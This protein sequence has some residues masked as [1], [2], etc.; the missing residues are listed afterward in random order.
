MKKYFPA[1]LKA[2]Q[3]VE[4]FVIIVVTDNAERLGLFANNKLTSKG[5]D[6]KASQ[7]MY[8]DDILDSRGRILNE[9]IG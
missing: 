4:L 8:M 6:L 5:Q 2:V 7:R 1:N 9:R 3:G